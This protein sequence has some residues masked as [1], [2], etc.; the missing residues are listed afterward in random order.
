MYKQSEV[1][2]S[3]LFVRHKLKEGLSNKK[4]GTEVGTLH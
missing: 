3:K 4:E 2:L 1:S